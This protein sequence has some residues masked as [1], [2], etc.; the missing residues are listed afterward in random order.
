MTGKYCSS[1]HSQEY[2]SDIV[3]ARKRRHH[4]ISSPL[5]RHGTVATW[6]L[7]RSRLPAAGSGLSRGHK[8]AAR[9]PHPCAHPP[10]LLH[11][12]ELCGVFRSSSPGAHPRLS[13]MCPSRDLQPRRLGSH[14]VSAFA[15]MQPSPLPQLHPQPRRVRLDR[16]LSDTG[17]SD[18]AGWSLAR[19]RLA[20]SPGS[21][22]GVQGLFAR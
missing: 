11:P 17:C 12:G 9:A 8:C 4:T 6:E 15:A 22:V 2:A 7:R 21:L 5:Q 1:I 18:A 20:G 19:W 10:V 13:F 3:T 16:R 14:S